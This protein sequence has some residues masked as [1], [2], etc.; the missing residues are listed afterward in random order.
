MPIKTTLFFAA[1][2]T[3]TGVYAQAQTP[4]LWPVE[5]AKSGQGILY[6][7]QSHIDGELNFAGLYITAPEG[8][9]VVAPCEG[10]IRSFTMDYTPALSQSMNWSID[11]GRSIDQTRVEIIS[12]GK[13]SPGIDPKFISGNI[14]IQTSD[15]YTIWIGGLAGDKTFKTGQRVTRGEPLGR[16]SHSYRKIAEPSI[17]LSVDKAGR[18]SDPMTPFGLKTTFVA[19]NEVKPVV[20]LT[21]EQAAEDFTIYIDALKEC[22]VGLHNVITPG[23]LEKYVHSTLAD[24]RSREGDI[25]YSDFRA[26]I[27]DAQVRIHDSHISMSPAGWRLPNQFAGY[28][29]PGVWF[30]FF[31][32]TLRVSNATER[33]RHLIGRQITSVNVSPPTR[34]GR[35]STRESPDTTRRVK[36]TSNTAE[37][38][39]TLWKFSWRDRKFSTRVRICVSP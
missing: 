12:S 2:L 31:N 3:A 27:A 35:S 33:F 14:G 18:V 29:V 8:A 23:E 5:G 16:V 13:L 15:G 37:Q 36:A 39:H 6:A 11:E 4:Y 1:L 24:I 17:S 22:F 10:T 32:D 19:P 21:R 7:P 20:S 38:P 28:K 25:P 34:C 26:L 9:V 30:G